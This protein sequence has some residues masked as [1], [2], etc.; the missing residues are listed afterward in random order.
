MRDPELPSPDSVAKWT[1]DQK[2]VKTRG[3]RENP[4]S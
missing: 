4:S 2:T 1:S 3:I